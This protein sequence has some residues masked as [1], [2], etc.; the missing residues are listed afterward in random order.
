MD[1]GRSRPRVAIVSLLLGTVVLL[2][3][4][5]ILPAIAVG[6]LIWTTGNDSRTWC[7][8]MSPAQTLPHGGQDTRESGH[9]QP[10]PFGVVCEYSYAI[11]HR[12]FHDMGTP[13][14]VAGGLAGMGGL[15]TLVFGV[16]LHVQSLPRRPVPR[17]HV[18]PAAPPSS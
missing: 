4:A 14:I 10:L 13:F 1:A 18:P 6:T 8:R 3:G 12:V 15:V 11:P 9:P 2:C 5:V 7:E 17:G 16:K